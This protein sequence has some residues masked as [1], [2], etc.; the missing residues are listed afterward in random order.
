MTRLTVLADI[1]SRVMHSTNGSPRTV[2]GGVTVETTAMKG[3]RLEVARLPKWKSCTEDDAAFA[4]DLMVS[5]AIAVSI[6]SVNR[7]T[8]EWS[9]FLSDAE[10]LHNA[11]MATSRKVAGWAKPTNLLKFLL[12]SLACASST[13]HAIRIYRGPCIFSPEGRRLVECATVCD[14]EIDGGENLEVF[15]SLWER[16][17]IPKSRLA[18]LG[19]EMISTEVRVTTE[20]LEPALLLADYAAG[21]GLAAATKEPGRLQLPLN[22]EK[23]SQLLSRLRSRGKLIAVDEEFSCS[24]DEIFGEVMAQ[25]REQ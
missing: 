15:E 13:G 18:K 6:V 21:L 24:Y 20:Q 14:S 1:A 5:Q 10:I 23:A 9:Q 3:I 8:Q 7:Q 19:I 17:H 16:Q 2:A 22:Q 4:V 25:A 12:I 11:I